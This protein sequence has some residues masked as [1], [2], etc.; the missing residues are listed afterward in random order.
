MTGPDILAAGVIIIFVFLVLANATPLLTVRGGAKVSQHRTP[1]A[2]NTAPQVP[3]QRHWKSLAGYPALFLYGTMGSGKTT[4]CRAI[5]SQYRNADLLVIDP[6]RELWY[7]NAVVPEIVEGV[8]NWDAVKNALNAVVRE[9]ATR[10]D[11]PNTSPLVIVLDDLPV[12][13]K[14]VPEELAAL[15][16][17]ALIIG[18]SLHLHIILIGHSNRAGMSGTKGMHDVLLSLPTVEMEAF[19][20]TYNEG[21]KRTPLITSGVASA[22]GKNW[23]KG[24]RAW[25]VPAPP[26]PANGDDGEG[27]DGSEALPVT[28][29]TLSSRGV[30]PDGNGVSGGVTD[31]DVRR[32]I[33]SGVPQRDVLKQMR[34]KQ[35]ARAARYKRLKAELD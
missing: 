31:D 13:A 9:V 3:A 11:V 35:S 10:T 26:L 19:N 1:A 18:R 12:L 34:G 2:H 30:T 15:N 27:D 28:R 24:F 21:G 14:S 17:E 23:H 29:V 33:S 8:R 6:K 20:G 4:L 22:A 32:L 5:L 7:P 25:A 16:N